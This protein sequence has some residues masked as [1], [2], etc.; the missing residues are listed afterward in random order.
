MLTLVFLSQERIFGNLDGYSMH[1]VLLTCRT[2]RDT[3]DSVEVWTRI[4]DTFWDNLDGSSVSVAPL[5]GSKNADPLTTSVEGSYLYSS[6]GAKL[7]GPLR[8]SHGKRKQ[9]KD[10]SEVLHQVIYQH[11]Y[12]DP[13]ASPLTGEEEPLRQ[14]RIKDS[15]SSMGTTT[16]ATTSTQHTITSGASILSRRTDSRSTLSDAITDF[17]LDEEKNSSSASFQTAQKGYHM[18]SGRAG[19][20]NGR[21]GF[22]HNHT[23]H[24]SNVP[25]HAA[26]WHGSRPDLTAALDSIA[27]SPTSSQSRLSQK[28]LASANANPEDSH[29][30]ETVVT[31]PSSESVV[32][33]G[34][35]VGASAAPCPPPAASPSH[36][37]NAPLDHSAKPKPLVQIT[38]HHDDPLGPT[39]SLLNSSASS[40]SAS[41][42]SSHD[43]HASSANSLAVSR[44]SKSANTDLHHA[45][46]DHLKTSQN[47]A[48]YRIRTDS[49]ESLSAY[50]SIGEETISR[51]TTPPPAAFVRRQPHHDPYQ[52]AV[53]SPGYGLRHTV[54]SP[55]HRS[56]DRRSTLD[57]LP[58]FLPSSV[59]TA[60][61]EDV[62]RR[63]LPSEEEITYLL[64]ESH[65]V[66]AQDFKEYYRL[67]ATC[68]I[69]DPSLVNPEPS[70]SPTADPMTIVTCMSTESLEERLLRVNQELWTFGSP[71]RPLRRRRIFASL[72][73]A[74]RHARAGDF[75]YLH[76]G[77][78]TDPLS[79]SKP[80]RLCGQMRITESIYLQ[81]HIQTTIHWRALQQLR[82]FS[83]E[84]ISL[85]ESADGSRYRAA[86][87]MNEPTLRGSISCLDMSSDLARGEPSLI[88]HPR[89]AVDVHHSLFRNRE[90][91]AVRVASHGTL[92]LLRNSFTGNM[93]SLDMSPKANSLGLYKNT[94]KDALTSDL[95]TLAVELARKHAK[96]ILASD[97]TGP[98]VGTQFFTEAVL[99][100]VDLMFS[101]E[102]KDAAIATLIPD[103]L[104]LLL[105]VLAHAPSY[106]QLAQNLC[107]AL[108]VFTKLEPCR[109][110]L[111]ARGG[112]STLKQVMTIHA[113]D[114]FVQVESLSALWRL[115]GQE[116]LRPLLD[117]LQLDANILDALNKFGAKSPALVAAALG[118]LWNLS[119]L[120]DKLSAR[121]TPTL[122]SLFRLQRQYLTNEHIQCNFCGLLWNMSTG[123]ASK[124]FVQYGA[125]SSIYGALKEHPKS[126]RLFKTAASLLRYIFSYEPKEARVFVDLGGVAVL[127][128][129]LETFSSSS[130]QDLF[131]AID[132][133]LALIWETTSVE[134]DFDS[135]GGLW[136]TLTSY[137]N[138]FA[139]SQSSLTA[140]L[141]TAQSHR[142]AVVTNAT[143]APPQRAPKPLSDLKLLTF[144]AQ[145]KIDIHAILTSFYSA[146]GIKS[147]QLQKL[148][149]T[150]APSN[151]QF[152]ASNSL[153]I[154]EHFHHLLNNSDKNQTY[155]FIASVLK[156]LL[157]KD[158]SRLFAVR[159]GALDLLSHF[160]SSLPKS[161]S[162]SNRFGFLNTGASD[163]SGGGLVA[164]MASLAI[165]HST[166]KPPKSLPKV[167]LTASQQSKSPETLPTKNEDS[168]EKHFP[169]AISSL[170]AMPKPPGSASTGSSSSIHAPSPRDRLRMGLRGDTIRSPPPGPPPSSTSPSPSQSPVPFALSASSSAAPSTP[171]PAPSAGMDTNSLWGSLGA[172]SMS[173]GI[174]ASMAPPA[175]MTKEASKKDSIAAP[176]SPLSTSGKSLRQAAAP[177]PPTSTSHMPIPENK[178][179]SIPLSLTASTAPSRV[180]PITPPQ[181]SPSLT[182]VELASIELARMIFDCY[183]ILSLHFDADSRSGRLNVATCVDFLSGLEHFVNTLSS[184]HHMPTYLTNWARDRRTSM[185][186]IADL[187]DKQQTE[188]APTSTLSTAAA[189]RRFQALKLSSSW[190]IESRPMVL[191]AEPNSIIFL[192]AKF[193]TRFMLIQSDYAT[194]WNPHASLESIRANTFA[195]KSVPKSYFEVSLQ[196]FEPCAT[197]LLPTASSLAR[198]SQ[199]IE[200]SQPLISVGWCTARSVF[201]ST[202]IGV[203]NEPFCWAKRIISTL[204]GN[205]KQFT[206]SV[207]D[208]ICCF[209]DTQKM[210][211]SYAINGVWNSPPAFS[212]FNPGFDPIV[213]I[214]YAPAIT[215][216]QGV[217]AKFH[218]GGSCLYSPPY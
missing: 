157:S 127:L 130:T 109:A 103:I 203:L 12:N 133:V 146:C 118:A 15:F 212:Q 214:G 89:A 186:S 144:C 16:T 147:M 83:R 42:A 61:A 124:L 200:T 62:L 77:Q 5:R 159:G 175:K 38:S 43:S 152:L 216:H 70:P 11:A 172:S 56:D 52:H 113:S 201:F 104:P 114:G 121:V 163:N 17:D 164:S 210:E 199:F 35:H 184:I 179:P 211:I 84:R 66:S 112:L 168:L 138:F 206:W 176:A 149:S 4:T 193:K 107:A 88:V 87:L 165:G 10:S 190:Q 119:W 215:L 34:H 173:S 126:A 60:P 7:Q 49:E 73:E 182:A 79:I 59:L 196:R 217:E 198:P 24:G 123:G 78:Y 140:A 81:A 187:Q 141:F 40:I 213:D 161:V 160:T 31:S 110:Y 143:P 53:A 105:Q 29:K 75:I 64:K 95:V 63:W 37:A 117:S 22:G 116:S 21:D 191:M 202:K 32:A 100:I 122:P 30:L 69:V 177:S 162:I 13:V 188:G 195:N 181:V 90:G 9:I 18:T 25:A 72:P 8:R 189:A 128:G 135:Q 28:S 134:S 207:G 3:A 155:L 27:E 151:A 171:A 101:R 154:A 76:K 92:L 218:Y 82:T 99:S 108:N 208:R 26:S 205:P 57:D 185:L 58:P 142:A 41:I 96:N 194:I 98:C 111:I 204:P 45:P 156:L 67:I 1:N 169:A 91:T 170:W 129:A 174:R 54:S 102:V 94:Y 158:P 180:T 86:Y 209:L 68:L 178:P 47:D 145:R 65:Q 23:T 14:L 80:I 139:S 46:P 55:V 167:D 125:V 48:F 106:L 183:S 6:S 85:R 192:D 50:N 150:A 2:F 132:G 97:G 44:A 166:E 36:S 33:D 148:L 131:F 19:A 137:Y 136:L 197:G 120:S 20:N 51:G 115:A 153:P 39:P 93:M 74:I 71:H